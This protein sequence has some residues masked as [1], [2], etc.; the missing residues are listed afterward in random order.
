MSTGPRTNG[1]VAFIAALEEKTRPRSL[2]GQQMPTFFYQSFDVVDP[3]IP[4]TNIRI[5]GHDA[6]GEAVGYYG[7]T[8][9]YG[10]STDVAFSATNGVAATYY[11]PG[12][13]SI[14]GMGVTESGEIW[15]NVSID[16]AFVVIGG[17][18][19]V[20]GVPGATASY[21]TGVNNCGS[22][23]G[24]FNEG[25]SLEGFVHHYGYSYLTVPG[26]AGAIVSGV[27]ASGEIVGNR[28]VERWTR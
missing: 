1:P 18:P 8:D 3:T 25:G 13:S 15:G 19:D 12:V 4:Y 20:F 26:F 6:A 5:T 23:Y 24:Y 27:A 22:I 7:V 14:N 17:V 28:D 21:V 16:F 9:G 11:I 10:D 2:S